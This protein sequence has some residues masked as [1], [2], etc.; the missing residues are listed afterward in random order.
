MPK[1]AE[2]YSCK[3]CN[4]I[5]SKK[6]N[7]DK[8]LTTAKHLKVTNEELDILA[9]QDSLTGLPNR[10]FFIN[11]IKTTEMCKSWWKAEKNT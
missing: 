3:K 2:I 4:F 1:N 9:N 11:S 5:C 10:S 6:S 7:Y 8:H